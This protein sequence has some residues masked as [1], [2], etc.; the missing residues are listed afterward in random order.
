LSVWPSWQDN[1]AKDLVITLPV[2]PIN[3]LG[4]CPGYNTITCWDELNKKFAVDDT[5]DMIPGNN[6]FE[7]PPGSSV[8]YY[9]SPNDFSYNLC[10]TQETS[11]NIPNSNFCYNVVQGNSPPQFTSATIQP[12]KVGVPYS[13]FISATDPDNDP[14]TWLMTAAGLWTNWDNNLPP[15]LRDPVPAKTNTKEVYSPQAGD[16][17][18]YYITV[19]INDGR[20]LS[21]TR[22]FTINISNLPPVITTP[23]TCS[24]SV[25]NNNLYSPCQ[26]TAHDPEGNSITYSLANAPS[27]ININASGLIAGTPTIAGNYTVNVNVADVYNA[28][29]TASFKLNVNTYCGDAIRQTL[30]MEAKGGLLDN[31][32]EDCDASANVA[33][34]PAD[35]SPVKQY[36]CTGACAL[37]ANCAGTCAFKDGWCGDSLVQIGY[38]ETCDPNESQASYEARLGIS[39]SASTWSDIQSACVNCIMNCVDKDGDGYGDKNTQLINCPASTTAFDCVDIPNG[40]DGLPGTLDDGANINPGEPDNCTQFD[41]IDNNCNGIV[42]EF[43]NTNIILKN[44]DFENIDPNTG[45][46]QFWSTGS[47]SV[48]GHNWVKVVNTQ[49]HSLGAGAQYSLQIHQD[50]NLIFPGVCSQAD[51]EH[52]DM[53]EDIGGGVLAPKCIWDPANSRCYFGYQDN[54]KNKTTQ[55][56]GPPY[57]YNAGESFC[58]ANYMSHTWMSVN[59]D[60]STFLFQTGSTY[61]VRYFYKGVVDFKNSMSAIMGY[62]PGFNS[63]CV[64]LITY[65]YSPYSPCPPGAWP[66]YSNICPLNSGYCC[67]NANQQDCYPSVPFNPIIDNNYTN[68]T[69]H[70]DAFVYLSSYNS[71][72]NYNTGLK[73]LIIGMIFGRNA[74]GPSGS[75]VFIDDYQLIE[76]QNTAV[77]EICVPDGSNSICPPGCGPANDPDCVVF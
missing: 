72:I 57:Y 6:S 10:A 20:G 2:D 7:P 11:Y 29:S 18:P 46:P 17:G 45:F 41:R 22:T 48:L 24:N 9:S 54:C 51:C 56:S 77:P 36:A 39:L 8:Y 74:T 4:S 26:I 52:P 69:M 68:W 40:P 23:L 35:S 60:V 71:I 43:A 37:G 61:I 75:D 53:V 3:R 55:P 12:G 21:A 70:S 42:D 19:T 31:G 27:G 25:R 5:N 33:I 44:T 63:Q 76:C 50:P 13:G 1:L 64:D 65:N 67:V 28:V 34:S 30:N 16:A 32:V 15:M 59:Y 58:W 14:I 66:P 73:Q 62:T 38:G 49:N 47:E